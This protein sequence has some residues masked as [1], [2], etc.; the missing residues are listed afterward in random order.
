MLGAE[1]VL[2]A[3]QAAQANRHLISRQLSALAQSELRSTLDVNFASVLESEADLAVVRA[4]SIVAQHRARLA[5]AV[6][7][8]RPIMESLVE[9]SGSGDARPGSPDALQQQAQA[10]RADLAAAQAQQQAAQ[11]LAL[12]EKRLKYPTLNGLRTARQIP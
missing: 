11:E 2:R 4:Q 1:A 12:A 10:Q 8:Q 3:A 7:S 9:P 5:T 6:G